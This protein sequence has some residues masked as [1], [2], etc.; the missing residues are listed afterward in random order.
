MNKDQLINLVQ[1]VLKIGG[2]MLASK[3]IM[4]SST[5]EAVTGGIIA[6]LTWWASHKWNAS[7]SPAQSQ[8]TLP[9]NLIL[10]GAVVSIF[11]AGCVGL[12]PGADPLVVR[13]E[14]TETV[15]K[16]TFDLVLGV[17]DS[18]RPFFATNAPPF[19]RFCEW[20]REPQTVEQTNTL[21]RCSAMLLSLDDVKLDYKA[22][23]VSSNDVF[24][25]LQTVNGAMAQANAWLTVVTNKPN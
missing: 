20:L 23:R 17:D 8:G 4:D 7:S 24:I 1:T 12:Q 22:A 21:P 18:N 15:A 11:A 6:V 16:S 3:G 25:V 5:W 14:Q 9:L 2:G 13:V 19:H 10:F